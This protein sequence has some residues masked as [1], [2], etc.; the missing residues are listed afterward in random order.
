MHILDM[1]ISKSV[2]LPFD[3]DTMQKMLTLVKNAKSVSE[4]CKYETYH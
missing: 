3:G 1:I 2:T 4:Y